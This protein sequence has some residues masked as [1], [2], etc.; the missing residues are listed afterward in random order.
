MCVAAG[1][2]KQQQVPA[3]IEAMKP[4]IDHTEKIEIIDETDDNWARVEYD[5][6]ENLAWDIFTSLWE[7]PGRTKLVHAIWDAAGQFVEVEFEITDLEQAPT[8]Y[9]SWDDE[10]EYD[11]WVA[12][13]K[14]SPEQMAQEAEEAEKEQRKKLRQAH[15]AAHAKWMAEHPEGTQDR[16]PPTSVCYNFQMEH[17]WSSLVEVIVGE[18][19][20]RKSK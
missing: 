1:G 10:E 4:W 6:E 3:V 15:I 16:C 5:E 7:G 20:G 2:L 14:K 9:E 13:G 18:P 17:P 12:N 19:D 11:E 8:E